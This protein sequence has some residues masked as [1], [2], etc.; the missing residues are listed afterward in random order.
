MPAKNACI[1]FSLLDTTIDCQAFPPPPHT[2]VLCPWRV[3]PP[4]FDSSW[5]LQTLPPP[6]LPPLH[7]QNSA[8]LHLFF[9]LANSSLSF[10][11]FPPISCQI[12]LSLLHR[13]TPVF[14]LR[15]L[16]MSHATW[17]VYRNRTHSCPGPNLLWGFAG[18]SKL[19]LHNFCWLSMPNCHFEPRACHGNLHT[20]N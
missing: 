10:F 5:D 8:C 6:P 15:L 12:G 19:A 17:H 1:V 7:K 18:K 14:F 13:R 3:P 20:T 9:P 16:C 4:S 2:A 11:L